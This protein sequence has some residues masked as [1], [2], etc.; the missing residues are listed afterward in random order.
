[1]WTC[2]CSDVRSLIYAF[3]LLTYEKIPV[4]Q[5]FFDKHKTD[6]NLKNSGVKT[7]TDIFQFF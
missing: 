5:I 6:T 7:K 3:A 1:M 4:M 2:V